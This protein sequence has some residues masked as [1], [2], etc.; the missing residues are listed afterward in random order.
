MLFRGIIFFALLDAALLLNAQ[1]SD[2]RGPVLDP[3]D[4]AAA[5]SNKDSPFQL[6]GTVVDASGAVIAGAIVQLRGANGSAQRIAQSDR[7]GYFLLAGL[8]AG[9]YQ[10]VVMNSGFETKEFLVAIGATG[11]PAPLSTCKAARMN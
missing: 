6:S 8:A 7:G 5:A 3:R 10:L 4:H 1:Q 11:A 2:L 9:S